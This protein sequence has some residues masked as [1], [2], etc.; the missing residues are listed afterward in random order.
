MLSDATS[1]SKVEIAH[2]LTMDV[3]EYSTLLIT[4]QTRVLDE[5]TRVVKETARFRR[6]D[7]A[8]KLVRVPTGDGILLVFFDDPQ[9]PIECAME[10][11]TALKHFESSR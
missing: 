4:E 7:A 3:I 5:L 8:G 6:S 2:V 10:I 11:A 9:A 1:D